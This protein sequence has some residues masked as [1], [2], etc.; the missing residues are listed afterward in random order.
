MSKLASMVVDTESAS[1][2]QA[3]VP[4]E[5]PTIPL[6]MLLRAARKGV[7]DFDILLA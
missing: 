2:R 3:S 6:N 1:E 7:S 4:R 5:G